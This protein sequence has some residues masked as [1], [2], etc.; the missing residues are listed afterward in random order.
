MKYI[1][2]IT[3]PA[4]Q[5]SG[6]AGGKGA[7]LSRLAGIGGFNVPEGYIVTTE[8]FRLMIQPA[9]SPFLQRLHDREPGDIAGL[10]MEVK[11]AIKQL[12]VAQDLR[13]ALTETLEAMGQGAS[14]AVRSSAT[15][16][17]LPE[18]SFAGQ[19]DSFL[20]VQGIDALQEAVL[21]CFASLYNAR[22]LSY[23]SKN[24]FS[25]SDIPMAVVL[26]RMVQPLASGVMFTADPM[27]SDR[28]TIVVEAVEG[29]GDAL[30]SGLKTPVT[31]HIRNEALQQLGGADPP[32]SQA[33]ITELAMLGKDIEAFCHQPQ[34]IEW[35][36]GSGGF[37]IVQSRAI[38][39]LFPSPVSADGFNRCYI[40]FAHMQMMTDVML[41]LGV[42]FSN[43]ISQVPLNESGGRLY[44]DV[45]HDLSNLYGRQMVFQKAA[46]LDPL[47][48]SALKEVVRRKAYLKS[49]PK[50]KNSFGSAGFLVPILL[51]AYRIKRN[52][53]AQDIETY[54]AQQEISLSSVKARLSALSG[55][56]ALD[57]IEQ[58]QKVLNQ[59]VAFDP[60]GFGMIMAVQFVQGAINKAGEAL[61]GEKNIINGLSLSVDHNVTSA[62]GL[63]LGAIADLIRSKPEATAQFEGAS[64]M[65]G[66]LNGDYGQE[67]ADAWDAFLKAYGMRC[68]GE[69]DITKPRFWEEPDQL[70]PS[71]SNN[72]KHL[73]DKHSA[74]MFAQG[75]K[76][77]LAL[78]DKLVQAMRDKHGDR[79]ARKLRHQIEVFRTFAGVREYPK[80]YWISRYNVYKQAILREGQAL[81]ASGALKEIRD[82][83]YLY[84]DELRQAVRT[85]KVE[86]AL[87]LS[88][89]KEYAS[90]QA[91]TPPRVIFSDGEVPPGKYESQIP[92]GALA[93]LGV[94]GGVVEGHARVVN[95]IEDSRI[96]KGDI[97]VTGFTDPSWTPAFV[98]IAGL[99]TEVGGMMTHGAV[100][101]REY[102]LPA[103]V[104]VVNATRLIQDGQRIRINGSE[105]YVELLP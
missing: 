67:I 53:S 25:E 97:L 74:A 48:D 101:T 64:T 27:T 4:M 18:A 68:P 88:R 104:G 31:W 66:L 87:I 6:L 19:L 57:L 11:A 99:V 65:A 70:M 13:L 24:H 96:E 38:T 39:T 2:P 92:D 42:S 81:V 14:L 12:E 22:A 16:E 52:G 46:N 63:A 35:C 40:S 73:A 20:H 7:S 82:L 71:L 102:G 8:A 94:S 17:D 100:I 41:P 50:G 28:H 23:R 58:D 30:V 72:V 43:M 3:D 79:K 36:Y 61:L 75:E 47:M 105:G 91:L 21:A 89:R 33:L 49:I 78:A 51:S 44:I 55:E 77:A 90:Y 98:S 29:L 45:T 86:E 54:L 85:C 10:S 103:V 95:R 34:D 93:G 80:Y 15:A 59:E 83:Y 37:H 69:I 62:M 5:N 9:L 76:Q 1:Y 56:A 60:L 84:F 32:L 26:Q